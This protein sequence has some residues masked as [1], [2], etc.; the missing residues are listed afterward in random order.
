MLCNH[1]IIIAKL[2]KGIHLRFMSSYN[3]VRQVMFYVGKQVV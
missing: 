3:I 2:K 1:D